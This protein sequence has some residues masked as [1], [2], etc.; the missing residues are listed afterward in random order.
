MK[1]MMITNN[2]RK[3]HGLPLWR[4]KNR[5]KR[6]YTRCN[7]DEVITAFLDYCN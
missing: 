7:A 4:K 6:F 3:M 2:Q 5:K 1:S